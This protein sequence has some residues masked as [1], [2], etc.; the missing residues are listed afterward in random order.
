MSD[1]HQ[2]QRLRAK[3]DLLDENGDGQISVEEFA[4]FC[5]D[6]EIDLLE[7]G[8]R[9]NR[10]DTNNDGQVSFEEFKAALERK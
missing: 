8:E 3:F 2:D 5:A 4:H 10:I 1:A 6:L 7:A 9:F